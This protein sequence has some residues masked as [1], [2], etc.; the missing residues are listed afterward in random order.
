MQTIRHFLLAAIKNVFLIWGT[1]I[2]A[3]TWF[4][5]RPNPSQTL[6]CYAFGAAL[7]LTHFVV[8]FSRT[9]APELQA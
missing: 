2:I 7:V 3:M 1:S 6:M 4:L 5:G 8:K 9:E